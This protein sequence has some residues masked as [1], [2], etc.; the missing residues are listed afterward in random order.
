MRRLL[1]AVTMAAV[2]AAYLILSP[3]FEK[4]NNPN[5]NVRVYMALSLAESQTF[6]INS[7]VSRWGYVNDKAKKG[8]LLFPGKASHQTLQRMPNTVI[9]EAEMDFYLTE[10]TRLVFPHCKENPIYV[11]LFWE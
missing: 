6:A 1:V 5:E 10:T 9:I 11:F 8:D 3:Y 4:L 7:V 2:A